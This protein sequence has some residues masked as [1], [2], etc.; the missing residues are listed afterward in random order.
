MAG[1]CKA[2]QRAASES[3]NTKL[4]GSVFNRASRPLN[5]STSCLFKEA[6]ASFSNNS[7]SGRAEAAGVALVMVFVG[8]RYK[9]AVSAS[10]KEINRIFIKDEIGTWVNKLL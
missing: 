10:A 8:A 4:P 1:I 5:V 6:F 7:K 9:T 3:N 2:S